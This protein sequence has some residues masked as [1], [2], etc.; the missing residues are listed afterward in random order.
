MAFTWAELWVQPEKNGDQTTN[1][2]APEAVQRAHLQKTT[3]T[4]L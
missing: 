3:Y 4:I 1:D 2:V